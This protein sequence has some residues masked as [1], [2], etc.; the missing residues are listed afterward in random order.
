M[1]SHLGNEKNINYIVSHS[2]DSLVYMYF[3][4]IKRTV[5]GEISVL[6]SE[7]FSNLIK[8]DVEFRSLEEISLFLATAHMHAF[9]IH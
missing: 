6:W 5:A 8:S 7:I 3:N 4:L 1:Q 9:C 2:D